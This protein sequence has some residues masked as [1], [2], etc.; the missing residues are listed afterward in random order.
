MKIS[1]INQML[2][3]GRDSVVG[4]ATRDG[5]GGQRIESQ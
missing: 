1:I 3:V 5:L 4:I 2:I